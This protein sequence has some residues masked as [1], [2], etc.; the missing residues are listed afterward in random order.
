MHLSL[1]L[2]AMQHASHPCPAR[3]VICPAL[4]YMQWSMHNAF[5]PI[6]WL[7]CPALTVEAIVLDVKPLGR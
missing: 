4:L 6:R 3:W 2:R 5:A 7:T 1:I